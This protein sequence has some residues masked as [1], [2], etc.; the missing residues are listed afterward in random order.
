MMIKP[1]S[2]APTD[3]NQEDL[4]ALKNWYEGLTRDPRQLVTDARAPI[5]VAAVLLGTLGGSVTS[6]EKAAAA[7]LNGKK[8]GRPRTRMTWNV[9]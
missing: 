9:T 2:Q 6:L 3:W 4:A 5:H 8:G 1:K 7:R